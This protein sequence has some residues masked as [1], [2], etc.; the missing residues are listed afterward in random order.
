M[1]EINREQAEWLV[2][3]ND[4][5]KRRLQQSNQELVIFLTLANR[6]VC[7]VKYYPNT[8]SKSYFL[9]AINGN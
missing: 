3:N 5:L 7:I 2:E 6:Q 9:Q 4:V 8:H 1:Q